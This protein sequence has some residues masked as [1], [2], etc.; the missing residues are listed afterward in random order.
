MTA[1]DCECD[2]LSRRIFA[3]EAGVQREGVGVGESCE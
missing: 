1:I 2:G 3:A